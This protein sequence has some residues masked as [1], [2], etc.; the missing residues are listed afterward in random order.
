MMHSMFQEFL[1]FVKGKQI[2]RES[3]NNH[4]PYAHAH[5]AGIISSST[6]IIDVSATDHMECAI[7]LFFCKRKLG[8][9]D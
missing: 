5:F 2:I 8:K 1:N 3:F 6:W 9:N 7:S 4:A